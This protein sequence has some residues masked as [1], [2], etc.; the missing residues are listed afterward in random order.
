MNPCWWNKISQIYASNFTLELCKI[1]NTFQLV[2]L[3]AQLETAQYIMFTILNV[4]N[5]KKL[6]G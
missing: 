3:C 5:G 6:P 2:G 1:D 4:L